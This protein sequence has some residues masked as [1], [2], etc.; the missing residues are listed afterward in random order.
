MRARFWGFAGVVSLLVA[1]LLV[2]GLLATGGPEHRRQEKLD[3]IRERRLAAI[4]DALR[5]HL[6][7]SGRLP[8]TLADLRGLSDK[9]LSDPVS[10]DRFVYEIV[11]TSGEDAVAYRLCGVFSTDRSRDDAWGGYYHGIGKECFEK[12]LRIPEP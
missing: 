2:V 3:G 5:Q 8:K 7:D 11:S 10:R 1:G 4:E 9:Q 12:E 6:R